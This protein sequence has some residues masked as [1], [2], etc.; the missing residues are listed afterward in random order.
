MM[1]KGSQYDVINNV[2]R[3]KR[4]AYAIIAS[5]EKDRNLV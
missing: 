5:I 3:R 2:E 4:N 1:A